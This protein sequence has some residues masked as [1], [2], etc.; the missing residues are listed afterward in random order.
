MSASCTIGTHRAGDAWCVRETILMR[1]A[2]ITRASVPARW[3]RPSRTTV[4][5]RGQETRPLCA[6]SS[7]TCTMGTP[8]QNEPAR[9]S[10]IMP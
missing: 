1:D 5:D 8:Q 4:T 10:H 6:T 7:R 3:A 9:A 2:I